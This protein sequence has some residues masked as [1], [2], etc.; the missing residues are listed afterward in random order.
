MKSTPG[1]KMAGQNCSP[2]LSRLS[3]FRSWILPESPTYRYIIQIITWITRL[4]RYLQV[5]LFC[6]LIL[7]LSVVFFY[8]IFS[9]NKYVV[10]NPFV[11]KVSSEI[12]NFD[13]KKFHHSV[14]YRHWPQFF[15]V[16][17]NA[18]GLFFWISMQKSFALIAFFFWGGGVGDPKRAPWSTFY[19]API[20][21]NSIFCT[22]RALWF[23]LYIFK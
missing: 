9:T 20:E 19:T 12:S 7:I 18:K 8:F 5:M 2:K 3:V 15:Q 23:T 14:C 21:K 4:V 16:W 6:S 1:L 10:A 22:K 17:L 11:S 13:Y